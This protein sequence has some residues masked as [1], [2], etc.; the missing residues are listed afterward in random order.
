LFENR[1]KYKKIRKKIMSINHS[2]DASALAYINLY[3]S[4]NQ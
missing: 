4:L 2:W 1:E 3:K